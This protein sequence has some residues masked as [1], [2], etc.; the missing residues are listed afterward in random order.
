MSRAATTAPSSRKATEQ[1]NLPTIKAIGA[2]FGEV[3][4]LAEALRTLLIEHGNGADAIDIPARA[5]VCQIG[6]LADQSGTAFG[7]A[8]MNGGLEDWLLSP[9]ALNALATV[10]GVHGLTAATPAAG[11]E[12]LCSMKA[13]SKLS[14]VRGD[15]AGGCAPAVPTWLDP[16]R[17]RLA[18]VASFEIAALVA[19]LVKQ[20]EDVFEEDQRAVRT[21]LFRIRTMASVVMSAIS[22]EVESA[23]EIRAR[24]FPDQE[25]DF[26]N[27]GGAA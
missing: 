5:L 27:V 6:A 26:E 16:L 7:W 15:E 13:D 20:I 24:A 17:I 9:S 12:R 19:L 22:D 8:P 18:L 2:L 4:S 10:R 14:R 21:V 23:A 11:S 25:D 1:A 3:A